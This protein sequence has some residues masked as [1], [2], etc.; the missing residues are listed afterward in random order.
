MYIGILASPWLACSREACCL[1]APFLQAD[2][3]KRLEGVMGNV[4]T[5]RNQPS[6]ALK[7]LQLARGTPGQCF[8]S[9][10]A[11]AACVH[12]HVGQDIAILPSF[13]ISTAR[14]SILVVLV[15]GTPFG[16]CLLLLILR[17]QN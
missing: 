13:A 17:F 14:S 10:G 8:I 4:A 5:L 15:A 16:N 9:A 11:I 7:L 6:T 12:M 2:L 1:P 3:L